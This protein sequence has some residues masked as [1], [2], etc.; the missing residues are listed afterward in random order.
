MLKYGAIPLL[1]ANVSQ[2]RLPLID[3]SNMLWKH[4]MNP[5][6][7]NRISGTSTEASILASRLANFA[8]SED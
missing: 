3:C 2:G 8:I 1:K 4:P 5:W 7:S 6:N